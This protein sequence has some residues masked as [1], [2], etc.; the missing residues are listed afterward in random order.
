MHRSRPRDAGA[1][2]QHRAEVVVD[3]F[4]EGRIDAD[5]GEEV[6]R[7]AH[8]QE[9]PEARAGLQEVVLDHR[10]R[11]PLAGARD[12]RVQ[13]RIAQALPPQRAGRPGRDQLAVAVQLELG[14]NATHGRHGDMVRDEVA[15]GQPQRIGV[16]RRQAAARRRERG[17]QAERVVDRHIYHAGGQRRA[18]AMGLDMEPA[19]R[20]DI[21]PRF[22]G[23][24]GRHGSPRD[25]R[26]DDGK[27]A[28]HGQA[29][30]CHLRSPVRYSTNAPTVK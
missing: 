7:H 28:V 16:R 2:R 6:V 30:Q 23:V 24:G 18:R 26:G 14:R 9:R 4:R 20:D 17:G 10:G 8:A 5:I 29:L 25:K 19:G 27:Q 15:E 3:R 21:V 22:L 11:A 13:R 12:D 1:G